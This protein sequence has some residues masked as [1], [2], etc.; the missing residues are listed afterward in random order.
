MPL[1]HFPLKGVLGKKGVLNAP[2][3][4]ARQNGFNFETLLARARQRTQDPHHP[5]DPFQGKSSSL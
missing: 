1:T 3:A 4:R 5:E 2:R